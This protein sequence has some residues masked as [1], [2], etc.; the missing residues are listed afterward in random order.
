MI[1]EVRSLFQVMLV[2]FGKKKFRLVRFGKKFR[3]VRFG[4]KKFGLVVFREIES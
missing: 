4:K 1:F 3:L 2:R